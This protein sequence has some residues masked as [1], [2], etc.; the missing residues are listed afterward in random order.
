MGRPEFDDSMASDSADTDAGETS[1]GYAFFSSGSSLGRLYET[2]RDGNLTEVL[3]ARREDND[4][5]A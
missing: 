4:E 2:A 1:I 5:S 3:G